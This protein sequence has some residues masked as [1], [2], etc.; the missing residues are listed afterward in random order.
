MSSTKK[1]C[2]VT[3]LS[4]GEKYNSFLLK[5]IQSDPEFG[6][7]ISDLDLVITTDNPDMFSGCGAK[8][9]FKFDPIF[10]KDVRKGRKN[11]WFNFHQKNEAIRNAF[12]LGYKKIFYI[13]SDIK[14]NNWNTK[15]FTDKGEGF[16]FRRLLSKE[17]H[18]EKYEFYTKLFA[19]NLWH[20]W[21]PVSE[22]IMYIN[23]HEH[24]INGFL[25]TWE[26]LDTISRGK[27]NPYTEGNEILIALRFNGA[28]INTYRTDPF[29]SKLK[30]MS[31]NFGR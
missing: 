30:Y 9:V 10:L 20:Y 4:S 12:E 25:N 26:Y 19:V 8:K 14:I 21:R 28:T 24:K 11:R 1:E 22:K 27:V 5:N 13:D 31:D 16:C 17:N 23:A 15:F 18:P 2:S 29:K 3:L 6:K 7:M